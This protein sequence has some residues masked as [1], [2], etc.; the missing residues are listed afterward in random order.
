[1]T[2]EI[3]ESRMNELH[4]RFHYF[5][6]SFHTHFTSYNTKWVFDT[7][8]KYWLAFVM[9]DNY[10]KEWNQEKQLWQNLL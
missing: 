3:C 4:Q 2:G 6:H 5:I 7:Y 10:K 1:M 8:E 9:F